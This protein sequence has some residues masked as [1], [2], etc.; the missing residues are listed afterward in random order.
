MKLM[1]SDAIN[2]DQDLSNWDVGSVT[3]FTDMFNNTPQLSDDNKCFI[4]NS[5]KSNSNWPYSDWESICG[6]I[7]CKPTNLSVAIG[8]NENVLSWNEPGGCEDYIIPSLPFYAMGNNSN[9]GDDWVV[10]AGEYQGDDVAYKLVLDEETTLN[11]STCFPDTEFDTKLSIFDG[12][13]GQ[14][15]YYNDDPGA[16]D[17][18]LNRVLMKLQSATDGLSAM[19]YGITLPAGTYYV[20]VGFDAETGNYGLFLEESDYT[21]SNTERFTVE[22]QI[23]YTMEKLNGLGVSRAEINDLNPEA[24]FLCPLQPRIVAEVEI[25]NV[26][27]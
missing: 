15:L 4:H 8:E 9:A 18:I 10:S 3:D 2:L 17:L 1:F 12:C 20:V 24:Y 27:K 7:S 16:F 21:E 23:P 25:S 26:V 22:N 6:Y 14:E 5:W 19:L 11:I 13:D